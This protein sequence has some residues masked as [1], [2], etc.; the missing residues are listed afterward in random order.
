MRA[1]R[2]PRNEAAQ[3]LLS[4]SQSERRLMIRIALGLG[5]AYVVF[6]ACWVWATRVRSR[7]P[8]H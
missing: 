6:L 1:D 8:R 3:Y 5:V 4:E 2:Y 7:P